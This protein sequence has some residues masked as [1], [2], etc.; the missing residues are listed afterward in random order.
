M[1]QMK[2]KASYLIFHRRMLIL[3]WRE[4]VFSRFLFKNDKLGKVFLKI[5]VPIFDESNISK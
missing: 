3:Y 5:L 1:K 2:L 4:N